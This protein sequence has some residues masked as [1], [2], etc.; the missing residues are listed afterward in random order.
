MSKR[1]AD[2]GKKKL[3]D[4]SSLISHDDDIEFMQNINTIDDRSVAIRSTA[5]LEMMLKSIIRFKICKQGEVPFSEVF[6]NHGAP[7]SSFDSKIIIAYAAGIITDEQKIYLN[8][9]RVI[10]NHFAHTVSF[11]KLSEP[12]VIKELQK[13][14]FEA[15]GRTV[16]SPLE[17]N[18]RN[19]KFR[20]FAGAMCLAY[21]I[22][23][24]NFPE[25]MAA[26]VIKFE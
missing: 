6:T 17:L 19:T 26:E 4:L 12:L 15:I 9:F 22:F 14:D 25:E 18:G 20:F 16:R 2:H 3:R 13:I 1:A 10:R 7:L 24:A 23:L 21:G 5:Y 8:A 11:A